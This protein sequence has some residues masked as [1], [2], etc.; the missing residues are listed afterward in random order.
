MI[1]IDCGTTRVSINVGESGWIE[2]FWGTPQI[3]DLG[4]GSAADSEAVRQVPRQEA[5]T[6][7]RVRTIPRVRAT[8]TQE[9]TY[10]S[11]G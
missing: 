6:A 2:T 3:R 7:K 4:R 9:L 5:K 11:F 10:V 1:N 8:T